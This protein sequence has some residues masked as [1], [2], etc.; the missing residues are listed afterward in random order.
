MI[1]NL[2]EVKK[3]TALKHFQSRK[4]AKEADCMQK[5]IHKNRILASLSTDVKHIHSFIYHPGKKSW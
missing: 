4:D 3:R 5:R 2:T 1:F